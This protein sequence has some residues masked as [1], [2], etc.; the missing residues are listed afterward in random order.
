[1]TETKKVAI[2]QSTNTHE[3]SGVVNLKVMS[4]CTVVKVNPNES[5]LSHGEHG[6]LKVDSEHIVVYRQD[7]YNPSTK[8]YQKVVD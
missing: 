7:E 5:I 1:M 4:D 2:E 6:N 8:G 3:L